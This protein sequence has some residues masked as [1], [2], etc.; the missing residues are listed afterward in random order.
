ML[1]KGVGWWWGGCVNATLASTTDI[2]V[3]AMRRE[4]ASVRNL[5]LIIFIS[6]WHEGKFQHS[7]VE[8]YSYISERTALQAGCT[9]FSELQDFR[10]VKVHLRVQQQV[11]QSV[12]TYRNVKMKALFFHNNQF[13]E[14]VTVLKLVRRLL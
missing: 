3:S 8:H 5:L 1:S 4:D 14:K 11:K 9:L 10:L 12:Q 13:H 6:S 7:G 2:E